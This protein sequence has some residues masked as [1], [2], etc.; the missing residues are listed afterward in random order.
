[1][2]EISDFAALVLVVTAGFSLAVL[3]T[4]LTERVPIPAPA[5][6]LVAAA[7]ASDVSPAVYE[8]VPIKTVERIA[9]VALIVILFN[10]GA[11]IGWRRFRASAGPILSLGILGTFATAGAVACFAHYVLGVDWTLAGLLGAALAP[12]DPA[13]M[14]SVL[15]RREIAGRSGTTLEGEAGVNDPA[16]IALM[17]ATIEIATSDHASLLAA[18]REFGVEMVVGAAIGIAGG[19]AIVVMLHRLRLPSEAMYPVLTLMV[20]G[21]LY[22]AAS[23]AHGSGFLAVFLAGLLL[24]DARVPYKGEIERFQGS[25]ASFAELAVFVGLG[26]T[27]DLAAL[28]TRAWL[29]GAALAVVLALVVRPLVVFATL[30]RADLTRAERTFISWSGL[31]GAVPILLAAFAVLADADGAQRLYGLVFV[32]VLISVVG[33]GTL[34]PYVARRLGIPMRVRDRT[35]WDISIGLEGEPGAQEYEVRSRSAADGA[36]IQDLPLGD[37]AWVTL[38]VREG[39]PLEPDASLALRA[40]DRLLVLCDA[41]RSSALANVFSRVVR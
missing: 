39:A 5:I 40:G 4:K 17:L 1:M 19:R 37:D 28:G 7:I 12:T 27:I 3:S 30:H 14:F 13:V 6:F 20:G 34:V 35:P 8:A 2:S 33:Q 26:L 29:E 9:V 25:L 23:L 32:V 22:G 21:V 38:V 15:G 18:G 24:G 36:E 16:G 41:D 10:G 11:E 31:K